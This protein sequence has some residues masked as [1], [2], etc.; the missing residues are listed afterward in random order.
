MNSRSSQ[1]SPRLRAVSLPPQSKT[2]RHVKAHTLYAML[3]YVMRPS[4]EI[5]VREHTLKE[6]DVYVFIPLCRDFCM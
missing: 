4:L 3:M 6:I 2:S 1:L 5:Y